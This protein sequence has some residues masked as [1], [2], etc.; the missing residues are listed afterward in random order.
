MRKKPAPVQCLSQLSVSLGYTFR[1]F[2][3]FLFPSPAQT[4]LNLGRKVTAVN[5]SPF[6]CLLFSTPF[7]QTIKHRDLST[8][9]QR[10]ARAVWSR[11]A[12]DKLSAA[13]D[14]R[15]HRVKSDKLIVSLTCTD[16]HLCL[17]FTT[18]EFYCFLARA[19][20]VVHPFLLT[21]TLLNGR[22]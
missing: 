15:S 13:T 5:C 22:N 9:K 10:C 11:A 12:A 2:F 19:L 14:A 1:L 21:A 17:F 3:I 7:D 16:L 8:E 6:P 4:V 18:T 20:S